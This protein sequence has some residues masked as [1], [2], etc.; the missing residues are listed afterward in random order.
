MTQRHHAIRIP[1]MSV[2]VPNLQRSFTIC[3][4]LEARAGR[5][6]IQVTSTV[7]WDIRDRWRIPLC[8]RLKL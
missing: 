8:L 1:M 4:K 5:P 2:W 6:P 3:I 7:L